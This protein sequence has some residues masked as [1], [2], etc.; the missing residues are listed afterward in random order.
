METAERGPDKRT[1]AEPDRM[2]VA[3]VPRGPK[4]WFLKLTGPD[5]EVATEQD[6][7]VAFLKSI[8]FSGTAG[9]PEWELPQGWRRLPGTGTRF[10]TLQIGPVERPLELTVIPLTTAPGAYDDYILANINRWREQLAQPPFASV[11]AMRSAEPTGWLSEVQTRDA[12]AV[13]FASMVGRARMESGRGSRGGQGLPPSH[14]PISSAVAGLPTDQPRGAARLTY[15]TPAGWSPG[16]VDGMR[17]AAFEVAD[18]D[19]KVEITAISLPASGGDRLANINRWRQQIQLAPT[20]ADDLAKS[21]VSIQIGGR[22]AEYIEILGPEDSQPRKAIL[23]A[24]LDDGALTW[25]F[26]LTGDAELALREQ[27]RFKSFVQSVKFATPM[28]KKPH[29]Q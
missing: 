7:F 13:T 19:R 8:R 18:G 4:T 24:L 9:E 11:Q 5:T 14:P 22:A 15:E 16:R 10:A 23:A 2:L 12:V 27:D 26:K 6:R 1:S 17:A 20:N 21:L 29:A 25:F 3:M 28:E